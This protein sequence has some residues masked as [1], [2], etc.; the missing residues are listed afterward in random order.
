MARRRDEG[1]HTFDA[2]E[3]EDERPW[4]EEQWEDF[5]KKGD[6]RAA[7]FGEVLETMRDEPDHDVKVA[8]EMGW[9]ELADGLE[10]RMAFGEPA[11]YAGPSESGAPMPPEA[12]ADEEDPTPFDFDDDDDDMD[13]D[14]DL[15]PDGQGGVKSIPAYTTAFRNGMRIGKLLD[16]FMKKS[17]RAGAVLSP[18]E[19]DA[20]DL[21]GKAWIGCHVAAAKVSGGHAMGYEDD[22]LCGNIVNCRR[23]LAGVDEGI[24][25]VR[26]LAA[27]KVLPAGV[28]SEILDMYDETRKAVEA[29]IAE[30]RAKVWWD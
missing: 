4:T 28:V 10:E 16:P 30:L 13:D 29:R 2:D 5:M 15:Y 17:D 7:R 19:E 23:G 1:S 25:A 3:P 26:E 27:S 12:D 9:N 18:Q 22:V 24:A 6:L 8:R 14:A 20:G 11:P 21:L